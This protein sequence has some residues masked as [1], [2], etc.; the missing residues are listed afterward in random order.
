MLGI[1][2]D[3]ILLSYFPV[4]LQEERQNRL[5]RRAPVD[6]HLFQYHGKRAVSHIQAL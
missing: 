4:C 2:T 1:F 3:S 6:H 5:L